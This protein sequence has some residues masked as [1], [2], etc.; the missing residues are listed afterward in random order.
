MPLPFIIAGAALLSAG[1]PAHIPGMTVDRMC[2]SGL[3]AIA[4]GA[5]Q[6]ALEV[7]AGNAAARDGLSRLFAPR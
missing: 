7:R 1:W 6:I 2:S 5:R 3:M 4:I